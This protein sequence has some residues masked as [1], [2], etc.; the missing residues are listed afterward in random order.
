MDAPGPAQDES[1]P[2]D[3]W[4]VV[5]RVLGPWG[6]R[7]DLRVEPHSDSRER[8]SP[9][10]RVYLDGAET[11]VLDSRPHRGGLVVRLEAVPDRNAAEKLKGASLTVPRDQVEPLPDG[12]YYYFQ[13]IGLSVRTD[14]GEELG[15]VREVLATGSNDVY[16]VR[17]PAGER[18]V[19][20]LGDVVL[21]VDLDR[22][23]MTVSLPEGL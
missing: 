8:F 14:A 2:D 5:G 4:V 15:E 22:G 11:T 17:G 19:P 23:Q 16:V 6:V 13:I 7:G 9:G 1:F 3:D 20:A 10:S 21:D 18:L 12:S